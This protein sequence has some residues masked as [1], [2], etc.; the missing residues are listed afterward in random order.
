MEKIDNF[1]EK[2]ILKGVKIKH[3]GFGLIILIFAFLVWYFGASKKEYTDFK[4]PN[5]WS[6]FES[7][8][9]KFKV[10]YPSDIL[11][12]DRNLGK[13]YHQLANYKNT[14]LQEGFSPQ[15]T[16]DMVITFQRTGQRCDDMDKMLKPLA[17]EFKLGKHSGTQYEMADEGK[18]IVYYCIKDSDG[19]NIFMVERYYLNESWGDIA[20]E[21]DFIKTPQ[22]TE[23]FNKI[24]ETLVIN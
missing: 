7:S 13:I 22:Q 16:M 23:L 4:N 9:A 2:N 11:S 24:I 19:K 15:K 5:N 6:T 8:L 14:N 12:I 20:N 10:A 17:K 1:L 18:G 21:P 3:V